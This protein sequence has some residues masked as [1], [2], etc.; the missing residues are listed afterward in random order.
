MS[1]IVILMLLQLSWL[2]AYHMVV[3]HKKSSNSL[4]TC[5]STHHKIFLW[6]CNFQN[7][8]ICENIIQLLEAFLTSWCPFKFYSLLLQR[9]DWMWNLIESFDEH[10]VVTEDTHKR[11]HIYH[12]PWICPVH[13]GF[14]FPGIYWYSFLWNNVTQ[15]MNFS[16]IKVTFSYICIQLMLP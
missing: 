12:I 1:S 11:S 4:I 15:I 8:C 5:I 10:S 6:V 7:W 9:S 14:H 2:I 3:L 13:N 16:F